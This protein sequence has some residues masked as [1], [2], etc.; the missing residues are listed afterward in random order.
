[1]PL[2]FNVFLVLAALLAIQSLYS[3]FEGFRFS[4][5]VRLSRTA[6]RPNFEP[7]A[8]VIVPVKGLDDQFQ[9]HVEQLLAQDYPGYGLIF[10]LAEQADPAYSFL[11]DRLRTF[12]AA[13][14]W[15]PRRVEVVV[16]GLTHERGEKV[17]NLLAALRAVPPDNRVLV[18]ADADASFKRDW[19]RS[20]IGPLSDPAVTVSTGF[21]WYLPGR[22]FASRLRAAW[23]ASIA[24]TFGD[25]RRN[26]AWG[27]SMAVR[28]DDFRRLKVAE[29]YWAGSVSDDYGL[30]RAVRENAGW[31]RFEPRCLLASS[32][33]T[34]LSQFLNWS[35]RQVI[36]TRVYAPHLWLQGLL[37]YS[38]FCATLLLGLGLGLLSGPTPRRLSALGLDAVI[39]LLGLGKARL[40]ESVAIRVFPEQ[41]RSL[42]RLGASYWLF[43]PFVPWVM[44]FNL[45]TAA[46]TRKI[47]WRGTCYHLVSPTTLRVLSRRRQPSASP[48]R[49]SVAPGS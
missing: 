44:L 20:L 6:P 3:L 31:I 35:N 4:R 23:D 7:Q 1:M 42:R 26:L 47:E 28:A 9:T 10:T 30:Y 41:G 33:E 17:N 45:V 48:A 22:T 13:R 43:W 40:R 12:R 27:G 46:L 29:C 21:R 24:T 5:F 11:A 38:F 15:G 36:I 39:L 25:H 34:T 18:F 32:E 16:A 37:S 2:L 19:L 14:G 49:N 8:A